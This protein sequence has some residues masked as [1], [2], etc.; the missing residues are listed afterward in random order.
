MIPVNMDKF[1]KF[2]FKAHKLVYKPIPLFMRMYNDDNS[3]KLYTPPVIP[4][5]LKLETCHS[6]RR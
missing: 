4:K 2:A 1:Q 6:E 5:R 3:Y